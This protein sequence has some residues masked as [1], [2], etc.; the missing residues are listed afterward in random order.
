LALQRKRQLK[1]TETR[2]ILRESKHV[3]S[4]PSAKLVKG[5]KLIVYP[6]AHGLADTHKEQLNNDLLNFIRQ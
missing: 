5:A 3:P 1:L 6:G 2:R 4:C